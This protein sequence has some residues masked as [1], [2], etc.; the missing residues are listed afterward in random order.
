MTSYFD[1][2]KIEDLIFKNDIQQNICYNI[3]SYVNGYNVYLP[4]KI[5]L[6]KLQ[7]EY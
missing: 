3:I 7:E 1:I 6:Y 4:F 2:K 5:R